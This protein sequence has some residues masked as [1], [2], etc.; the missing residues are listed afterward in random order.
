LLSLFSWLPVHSEPI[1]LDPVA[2]EKQMIEIEISK[3]SNAFFEYHKNI[4]TKEGFKSFIKK[5][6]G[7]VAFK[8]NVKKYLESRKPYKK[9]L[10]YVTKNLE[11]ALK[12]EDSLKSLKGKHLKGGFLIVYYGDT[13]RSTYSLYKKEGKGWVNVSYMKYKDKI[14]E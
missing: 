7:K 5:Q 13:F 4:Y 6:G 3:D 8:A 14:Y 12:F 10:V 9:E 11:E 1:I 2:H